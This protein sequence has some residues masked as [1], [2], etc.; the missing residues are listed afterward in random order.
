ML[1]AG[2]HEHTDARQ[3]LFNSLPLTPACLTSISTALMGSAALVYTWPAGGGRQGRQGK[4]DGLMSPSPARSLS[5][6][7]CSTSAACW[8][9]RRGA[10]NPP[11][12]PCWLFLHCSTDLATCLALAK[13]NILNGLFGRGEEKNL[14]PGRG[15][16]SIIRTSGHHRL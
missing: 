9:G 15:A 14:Q 6:W 8:A 12:G 1:I 4:K 10:N 5:L 3:S 7:W 2:T 13:L 16:S 11:Q